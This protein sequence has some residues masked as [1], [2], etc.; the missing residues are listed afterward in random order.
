[1]DALI[2]GQAITD[3]KSYSL[4]ELTL[5]KTKTG[6]VLCVFLP[7]QQVT[8]DNVYD[9]IVKSGFQSY[10]DVYRDIP[11]DQRPPKP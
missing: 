9:L 7:V 8:K 6:D 3:A 11:A 5:D 1:M 2:K 10:D 4:A